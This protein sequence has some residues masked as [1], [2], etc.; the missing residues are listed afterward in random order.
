MGVN[1]Y[2]RKWERQD[3]WGGKLVE[4]ITQAIARDLMIAALLRLDKAGYRILLTVHDELIVETDADID[5]LKNIKDIIRINPA[6]AD[7]L[8]TDCEGWVGTRYRK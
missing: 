1:Q 5:H 7:G 3:T 4:N 8:P 6:W 2:T